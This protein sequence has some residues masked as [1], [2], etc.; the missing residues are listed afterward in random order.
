MDHLDLRI[1]IKKY[2]DSTGK[3]MPKFKN[4]LLGCDFIFIFIKN[5][6]LLCELK[7]VKT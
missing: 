7:F 6:E 1:I 5:A 2:L 3:M 4:N